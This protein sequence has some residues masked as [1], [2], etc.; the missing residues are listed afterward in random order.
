MTTSDQV[1]EVEAAVHLDACKLTF[2]SAK[3]QS[4]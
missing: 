2:Y 1:D 3:S 4:A